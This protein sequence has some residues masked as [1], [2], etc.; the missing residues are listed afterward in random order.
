MVEQEV[1]VTLKEAISLQ[2]QSEMEFTFVNGEN[3]SRCWMFDIL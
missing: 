1:G 3:C 2:N